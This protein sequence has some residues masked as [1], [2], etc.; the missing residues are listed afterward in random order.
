MEDSLG[1][2][3]ALLDSALTFIDTKHDSDIA[4][5]LSL[6][7]DIS[8]L[9]GDDREGPTDLFNSLSCPDPVDAGVARRCP[10]PPKVST[11]VDSSQQTSPTLIQTTDIGKK[12]SN[13]ISTINIENENEILTLNLDKLVDIT[14][15]SSKIKV[16]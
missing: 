8:D 7:S 3:S 5:S 16:E 14:K 12:N 11:V 10:S 6:R 4:H 9:F 13:K 2:V 15:N 1:E